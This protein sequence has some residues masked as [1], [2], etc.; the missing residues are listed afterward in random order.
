MMRI[1]SLG[2]CR[3]DD[4]FVREMVTV[5]QTPP[6]L[7]FRDIN[8]GLCF[9]LGSSLNVGILFVGKYIKAEKLKSFRL[10]KFIRIT[11]ED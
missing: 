5:K 3:L 6:Y 2:C 4:A 9:L 1:Y 7:D 8:S 11:A 10:T